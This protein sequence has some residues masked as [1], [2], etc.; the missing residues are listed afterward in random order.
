[1]QADRCGAAPTI[2]EALRFARERIESV[3]A[4]A[5]LRMAL[6]C[7][8]SRLAA[9]PEAALN[10]AQWHAYQSLVRR[11][12]KGEP[13]AY[14]VGSREFYGRSFKVTPAVLIPRPETELLVELVLGM[15]GA[16]ERAS[17]LDLGTGSGAI[18][19]TLALELASKNGVVSAVD[20]SPDALDVA[21]H[22][23]AV[24]GANI[25]FFLGSWY[26]P[27]GERQFEYIVSNPPYV[28]ADDH[29]LCEGDLRF[30][31]HGAL[32]AGAD[33]LDDLRQIVAGAANHLQAGGW[34]LMEHGYDQAEDVRRL[35]QASGFSEIGSWSDLAGIPRVSGGRRTSA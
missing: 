33:G 13:V 17:V 24:L 22:N 19:I 5:L 25:G 2:A 20:V 18:G 23:A 9:H 31:P 27:L 21:R 4:R 26:R 7:S 8:A 6:N 10:E 29:H 3:D 14:L 1:M 34:L 30:E 12:G 15:I 16:K 35:L 28:R 32:A 11:R